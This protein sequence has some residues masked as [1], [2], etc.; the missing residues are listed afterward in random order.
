MQAGAISNEMMI[1]VQ[2]LQDAYE[3]DPWFGRPVKALL[4]E[5]DEAIAFEKPEGQHSLLELLWHMITWRE[6]TLSRLKPDPSLPLSYF[7]E[8]DW[9]PLDHSDRQL[10]QKGLQRLEETQTELT[11][12]LQQQTDELLEK[13]VKG[14]TYNFRKL[15]PGII[16]HDIYHLGQ[17][18]Y[19]TKFLKK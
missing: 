6:F 14:R 9:R 7:E 15:L 5:V 19:I 17:V 11:S 2:Q 8:N 12:I 18:A 3:G 4:E 13:T 16:Q 1:I 10:W